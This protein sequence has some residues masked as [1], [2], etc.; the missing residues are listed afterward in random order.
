VQEGCLKGLIWV[1]LII[2]EEINSKY[3]K[4]TMVIKDVIRSFMS[5][6]L[7]K[8]RK[9]MKTKMILV[10]KTHFIDSVL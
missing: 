8:R 10:S 2:A 6:Y 4:A 1:D 5:F 3:G 7:M 9:M